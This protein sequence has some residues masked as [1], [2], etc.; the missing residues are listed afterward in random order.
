MTSIIIIIIVVVVLV[1]VVHSLENV[2]NLLKGSVRKVKNNNV[3]FMS[4]FIYI[5]LKLIK[6]KIYKMHYEKTTN[7]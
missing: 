3:S 1:V 4:K 7:L 2:E 5:T 6:N